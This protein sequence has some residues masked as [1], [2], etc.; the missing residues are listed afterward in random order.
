MTDAFSAL[1]A[2]VLASLNTPEIT[3]D[4]GAPLREQAFGTRQP[5]FPFI[6]IARHETRKQDTDND[7]LTEHRLSL[8]IWTRDTDRA[9]AQAQATRVADTLR[10][11]QPDLEGHQL[12]LMHPTFV[13]VFARPDGITFRALIRIRALTQPQLEDA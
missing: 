2:S 12:I 13:D 4:F 5:A 6:R 9:R 10:D 7:G 1:D 3:A 11:A 8:E